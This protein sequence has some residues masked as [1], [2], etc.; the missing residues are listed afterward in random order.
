MQSSA[1]KHGELA[2]LQDLQQVPGVL[3]S[4]LISIEGE[5]LVEHLPAEWSGRAGAAA[6]R[7]AVILD[8]LSAGR[9]IHA[10][11]LRFFEHRLHVLP[12]ASGFLCVL[13]ELWSPSAVLKMAMN[14][15]AR[16]LT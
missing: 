10:F 13:C 7:L 12:A 15:V 14:V 9:K 5:L 4:M 16:R 8:A 11:C 1:R 2:F 3:G 6:P